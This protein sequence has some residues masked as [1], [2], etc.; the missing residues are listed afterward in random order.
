LPVTKG[1]LYP[2]P[3]R[4]FHVVSF[5]TRRPSSFPRCGRLLPRRRLSSSSSPSVRRSQ[6]P[7]SIQQLLHDVA[8]G[9]PPL[10]CLHPLLLSSSVYADGKPLEFGLT[11]LNTDAADRV[12]HTRPRPP[13]GLS[14][15]T[16]AVI[17]RL[18]ETCAWLQS[19]WKLAI[20]L[21]G[22]SIPC[23]LHPHLQS[24]VWSLAR[25]L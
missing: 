1:N 17:A 10:L 4:V 16:A 18:K 5:P 25:R 14:G 24:P 6:R 15:P 3:K 11:S 2:L 12:L 22:H 7:G 23:C 21:A 19:A 9:A 8:G 20:R 13:L